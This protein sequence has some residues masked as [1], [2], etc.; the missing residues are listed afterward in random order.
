MRKTVFQLIDTCRGNRIGSQLDDITSLMRS[1]NFDVIKQQQLPVLHELLDYVTKESP[2]Y[3]KY[4]GRFSLEDFP[5][6]NKSI[7]KENFDK[8]NVPLPDKERVFSKY[9]WFYRDSF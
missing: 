6:V 9:K 7:I 8:I 5:V 2:F 3:R 1:A 4:A